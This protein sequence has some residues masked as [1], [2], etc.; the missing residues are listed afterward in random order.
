[1]SSYFSGAK[2]P[3][4]NPVCVMRMVVAILIPKMSGLR[5]RNE[6]KKQ[7]AHF[8]VVAV[9]EPLLE[10]VEVFG[11]SLTS[12]ITVSFSTKISTVGKLLY[13]E[14]WKGSSQLHTKLVST[15]N[16]S[17]SLGNTDFRSS[18]PTFLWKRKRV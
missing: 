15:A 14:R 5:R 1:M 2:P 9:Q 7:T 8:D 4:T 3:F 16:Q 13:P 10:T 18:F 17:Q 6:F 11:H 12:N